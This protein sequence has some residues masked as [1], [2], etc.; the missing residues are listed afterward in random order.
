MNGTITSGAFLRQPQVLQLVP[1][2]PATLWRRVKA[3]EFPA[4]VKLGPRI[5]AWE[6]DAVRQWL[7]EQ[8]P[9]VA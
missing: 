5:T 2:S 4:P 1:I 7:D 9:R 8:K 3:G 6:A